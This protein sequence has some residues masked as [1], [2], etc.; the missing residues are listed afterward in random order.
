MLESIIGIQ[1]CSGEK[2]VSIETIEFMETY[3]GSFVKALA[4]TWHCADPINKQKLESTFEYFS[5]YETQ[6]IE[7][8]K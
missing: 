6:R 5:E 8:G 7:R 4:A 3:G 1:E 2:M